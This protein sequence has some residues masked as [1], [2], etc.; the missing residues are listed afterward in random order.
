MI[1]DG[2]AGVKFLTEDKFALYYA[3]IKAYFS[4][5]VSFLKTIGSQETKYV[6]LNKRSIIYDFYLKGKKTY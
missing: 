1:L 3:I 2:I 5:Y 4:F 6:P